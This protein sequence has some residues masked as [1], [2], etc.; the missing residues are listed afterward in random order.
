VP[1]D[2]AGTVPGSVSLSVVRRRALVQPSL[3]V[4]VALAGGPGQ[5]AVPFAGQF[6]AV[7]KA[8]LDRRDLVVFDQRGTGRSGFLSCPSLNGG[9]SLAGAVQQ[10]ADALGPAREFYTTRDTVEDIEALRQALGVERIALYGVSYGTHVALAYAWRYR[11]HAELLLLDSVVPLVDDD[12]LGLRG[13]AA[14]RRVLRDI[15]AVGCDGITSDPVR[16]MARLAKRWQRHRLRGPV[17]VPD[18]TPIKLTLT[19]LHLQALLEAAGQDPILRAELPADVRSTLRG[20]TAPILRAVGRLISDSTPLGSDSSRA[21]NLATTC[22]EISWPWQRGVPPAKRYAQG[23]GAIA[24]TPESAFSP[25]DRRRPLAQLSHL[26]CLFWPQS[27]EAPTVL[28]GPFPSVPALLLAGVDDLTTPL[29]DARGVARQ[30]PGARLL[31]VPETGHSVLGT[32]LSGCASRQVGRFFAGASI[33]RCPPTRLFRPAPV[34][35][36][37]LS[38]IK[39]LPPRIRGKRGRTMT[40]VILTLRDAARSALEPVLQGDLTGS[41]GQGLRG[42]TF[43]GT[44]DKLTLDRVVYVPGV[45]ISGRATVHGVTVSVSGGAAA[46]GRLTIKNDRV[47]G[48]LDGLPVNAVLVSAASAKSGTDRDVLSWMPARPQLGLASDRRWWTFEPGNA[49]WRWVNGCRI[50]VRCVSGS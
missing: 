42:G 41:T 14:G 33:G 30:L 21:L 7:L 49:G 3:G 20:D 39:V 31:E 4:L 1:L 8:G 11:E 26:P 28:G 37:A 43:H 15:C 10:C 46:H 5:A 32:E 48:R 18:G 17:T 34:A 13:Y 45:V 40:A 44:P 6:A 2:H 25:F 36:T 16:D 29:E 19:P 23:Q 12:P 47:S 50:G 24:A 27:P 38:Q 22:A 9:G 35:P